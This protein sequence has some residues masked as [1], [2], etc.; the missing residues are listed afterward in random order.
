MP[1]VPYATMVERFLQRLANEGRS[2]STLA[3]YR[4]DLDDTMIDVAIELGLLLSRRRLPEDPAERDAA[5]L[6]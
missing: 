6:R 3:A 1:D 2:T 5:V 4:T